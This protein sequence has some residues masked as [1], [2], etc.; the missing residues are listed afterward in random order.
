MT[1]TN[2]ALTL[3]SAPGLNYTLEYKDA[4]TDAEWTPIF[5]SVI[6]TGIPIVLQDTNGA[7]LPSRFYR[8]NCN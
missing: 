5:P 4:L 1:A 6:G 7:V 3:N 2:V 8:V